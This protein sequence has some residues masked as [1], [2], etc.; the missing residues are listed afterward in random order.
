MELTQQETRKLKEIMNNQYGKGPFLGM[1][2]NNSLLHRDMTTTELVQKAMEQ[3]I[4]IDA[5]I[6]TE[7]VPPPPIPPPPNK[8]GVPIHKSK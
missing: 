5:L 7:A 1:I 3:Q 6:V 4:D 2:Y 8:V